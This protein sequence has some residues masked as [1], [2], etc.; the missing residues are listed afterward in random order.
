MKIH[1][2][3]QFPPTNNPRLPPRH[4]GHPTRLPNPLQTAPPLNLHNLPVGFPLECILALVRFPVYADHGVE[5]VAHED[6][7]G[8]RVDE[9]DGVEK[10]CVAASCVYPEVQECWAE[11]D[12][13][14]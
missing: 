8:E 1:P 9:C 6:D 4:K 7:L 3:R 13:V 2:R 14:R 12:G 11:E 5:R 10:V